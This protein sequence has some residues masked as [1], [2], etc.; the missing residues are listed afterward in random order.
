M[1]DILMLVVSCYNVFG[2][3]YYAAFG[4]PDHF[5][6]L[7]FDY[8]VGATVACVV[9]VSTAFASAD[10]VAARCFDFPLECCSSRSI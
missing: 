7:V 8:F 4:M 5:W 10:V 2:N 9:V 1:Y 6:L 3:A